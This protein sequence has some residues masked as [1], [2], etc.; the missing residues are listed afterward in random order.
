[1]PDVPD[2]SRFSAELEARLRRRVAQHPHRRP[3]LIKSGLATGAATAAVAVLALSV[4]GGQTDARATA[5]IVNGD[6][7]AMSS[8]TNPERLEN[9]QRRFARAGGALVVQRRKVAPQ[10]VGQILGVS[11]PKDAA[12][13]DEQQLV[14]SPDLKGPVVVTLGVPSDKPTTAGAPIYDTVPDLCE[15]VVPTDAPTTVRNLRR[16]GFELTIKLIRF[17]ATG[18]EARDVDQAPPG[19]LV[20]GVLDQQGRNAGVASDTRKLVVEVGTGGDGHHGQT[21]SACQAPPA[22]PP[23]ED[24]QMPQPR[25][26]DPPGEGTR[27]QPAPQ[28]QLRGS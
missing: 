20:I 4:G 1:M 28:P 13:N 25:D 22:A 27:R 16:N 9:L 19:T 21:D 10:S 6:V 12:L 2:T 7:V 8:L 5:F 24:G 3:R 17:T 26:I 11:L 14:V 15:L 18:A 23:P